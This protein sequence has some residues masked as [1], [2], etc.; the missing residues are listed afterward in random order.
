MG[1]KGNLPVLEDFKIETY[2]AEGK[3]LGKHN[4]LVIFVKQGIPGDVVDLQIT[5]KRRNYWEG[6]P[7]KYKKY[8]DLRTEPFCEHFGVCGG[9]KWQNLKY[10][11]QLEYKQKQVVDQ[12]VRIGKLKVKEV[13]PIIGSDKQTFYRNKL[14]FTFSSNRWISTEEIQTK[15]KD[16]NRNA[17]GFHIPGRFDRILDINQCHLQSNLSNQIRNSV[18]KFALENKY[19]FYNQSEKTGFLRNIIIRDTSL[20]DTMVIVVFQSDDKEKIIEI[21]EF[22]G[23]RFP[24]VTSL[25][26]MINPKINDAI[27][28]LEVVNFSG[29]NYITEE[30]NGIQ[31][32]IGPKS[33]F[34]TNVRQ[35]GK[36]YEVVKEFAALTGK[37]LVYDLYTG[38]GTIANYIARE[39]KKVIGIE[40]IKQAI[41]NAKENSLLNN[42]RNTAFFVGDMR[43]VF[44]QNFV[45]KQGLPDIVI[46]DPPR[47][48]MHANVVKNIILAE[49]KILVYVSC[50]A[51]TQARDLHLLSEKY[52]VE[53]IQPVDMFPHT[54]HV[55]NVAKLT[56]N[57]RR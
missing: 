26:Y 27:H 53:T 19:S 48:G 37:E 6:Y 52:S 13:L 40:E 50:N 11:M 55:E 31:Y 24:E 34:Q 17:L 29:K 28:D 21:M 49:P 57:T 14:E 8:S 51:A 1:K 4:N 45:V 44:R 47:A 12:L 5:R 38:I 22:I 23:S 43:E 2:A 16:I 20:G 41:T 7:L 32:K 15:G 33:F 35:T 54:H 36:L 18:K 56:L 46:T 10:A 9:C 42:I 39:C 3:S 25:M 30:I